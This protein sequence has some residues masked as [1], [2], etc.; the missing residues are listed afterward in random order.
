MVKHI[1]RK[2]SGKPKDI[3]VKDHLMSVCVDATNGIS[4]VQKK[5]RH[6][7]SVP[8]HVQKKTWGHVHKIE[9]ELQECRQYH[10]MAVRSG[11]TSRH[12]DHIRSLDYCTEMA[13]EEVLSELVAL[14]FFGEAKKK[15][16]LKRQRYAK[17]TH[18]P[19]CVQV[20]L[21]ES[22]KHFCFSIHEPSVNH[23]S[24]LRRV[25]VSY[26]REDNTWHCP[27]AKPRRSCVHKNLSKW[28]LFQT[29]RDIFKTEAASTPPE[30]HQG[31]GYPPSDDTLER[32]VKYL[33]SNKK[34]PADLPDYLMKPKALTD[35]L[36]EL[37]PIE[38]VCTNCPGSV[39]LQKSTRITQKAKLISMNGV[40]E[41]VSTYYRCCPQCR[42]VYRY[43][44]WKDSLHNFD[45][46][47]ILTLELCLYLRHNLQNN[48]SVSKVINSL[49]SL[50]KV[51]FP[52][53][54]TILHAYCHFEA[55]TSHNYSYS[56]VCCGFF[57]PVVVMDL[58]KKGVFNLPV[59][60]MKEP[61]ENFTGDVD[62]EKFWDSVQLEMIA[63]GFFPSRAKNI[64]AVNPSFEHWSPW[65]GKDTQ[66]AKLPATKSS[67]EAEVSMM[68]E[69]RLVDELLKQKVSTVR[70]LCKACNLDSKGSRM[71]LVVRLREEMKTRH[72]Y[73]KIFQ[74]IWGASGGW[75]VILCP[76]GVVYSLKFNLRA[77]S[78]RDFTDLLLSWKHLPNVSVYDFARGLATHANLRL[79]ASLTFKPHEG[80]L[81]AS[82][83]D[84]I[85][86]AQ[87]HKLSISLPWLTEKLQS[88]EKDGHPLT[89]SSDHYVLY[90]K[91]HEANTRDP[92]EVLRRINLVPELQGSLNSQVAEQ[93][94]SSMQK[95]NYYLNNMAPSTHIFLMRNIIHLRNN[96]TNAKLVEQQLKRGREFHHSQDITLNELGQAVLGKY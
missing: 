84:N 75:S 45:D 48:V 80:R 63:R 49:E 21:Q 61:S 86:A 53:R 67:P 79:P 17:A 27:C 77:E 37:H 35:H 20:S 83:Q 91:F 90:D 93:L 14:K 47:T 1:Q 13:T 28:H 82:S 95:N 7:F 44:E 6:G 10:L 78:P 2:H 12:C 41:N 42:M 51:K 94:F 40:L 58:H 36:T 11:M 68:S 32:L 43:Q 15:T 46:H 66:F 33:Y 92:Q 29:N 4:A 57:P 70:K 22:Q 65:I 52:A 85:T 18:V 89:G 23:Y 54:D 26:N 69:D 60:D 24:R 88:P 56:C 19:L 38:T 31:T 59:S 81:A 9:C 39:H 64:F 8:I 50:R 87:Q 55:L 34:I 73:D 5:T 76:H 30:K 72:S 25:M 74:K 62:I 96:N 71:D 3:T 16:C